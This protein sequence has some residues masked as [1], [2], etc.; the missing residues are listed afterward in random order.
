[1]NEYHV[2]KKRIVWLHDSMFE[3]MMQRKIP[4]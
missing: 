2:N 4:R 1:M 3:V